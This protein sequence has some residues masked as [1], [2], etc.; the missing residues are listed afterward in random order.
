MVLIE[1]VVADILE[2]VETE[3]VSLRGAIE[4][5]FSI[6]RELV[7]IRGVVLAMSLAILRR[8][9]VLDEISRHVLGLDPYS[10]NAYKRNLLRVVIYELRF[11]EHLR[12]RDAMRLLNKAG[13]FT[14]SISLNKV[15]SIDIHDLVKGKSY[16]E[17]LSIRYSFPR[18][19]ILKL[20]A[21]WNRTFV[22]HMLKRMNKPSTLW[23]RINT[24]KIG[25]EEA[26]RGLRSRGIEAIRDSELFDVLKVVRG[27]RRL[28]GLDLVR[29][30]L[31]Y[32]QD[33]ASCAVA[34]VLNPCPGELIVDMCSAP[35]SKA[36]H[37][38]QLGQDKVLLIGLD[39]S[40]RRLI[41]EQKL[42]SN[43]GVRGIDLIMCDSRKFMLRTKADKVLVDPDCSSIGKMG[44][45]PELRL[46]VKEEDLGRLVSLQ[47]E[48]MM[49]AI[50]LCRRG[51]IIVYSTCTTTT[52][53]N[54]ALIRNIIDEHGLEV[55]EIAFGAKSPKLGKAKY[56]LPHVH[57]TI[58]FFIVKLRV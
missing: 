1:K 49:R 9:R 25:I 57:D 16:V 38:A 22:E 47:R 35:G 23:L 46:K 8:Y 41:S 44:H 11:R 7:P 24:L 6:H 17:K 19:V 51:G 15:R 43:L 52:E 45:S 18:W 40:H 21:K 28:V 31:V 54:E 32:I 5:F 3:P 48:L 30:G 12:A 14:D 58:G 37:I 13:L 4:D 20:L 53:E 33:K 29:N 55:E 42:A 56:F 2:R 27:G 36:T 39:I 10:V 50:D 34:H 26:M